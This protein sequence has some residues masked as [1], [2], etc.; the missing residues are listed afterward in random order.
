[1]LV[2]IKS[3]DS[4]RNEYKRIIEEPENRPRCPRRRKDEVEQEDID[5]SIANFDNKISNSEQ[6]LAVTALSTKKKIGKQ[7]DKVSSAKYLSAGEALAA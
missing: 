4:E 2:I 3:Y 6:R 5:D 7:R 1:M